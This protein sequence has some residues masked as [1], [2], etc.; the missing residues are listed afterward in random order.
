MEAQVVRVVALQV[1]DTKVAVGHKVAADTKVAAADTKVAVGHKVAAD[2]KVVA[3]D[4]KVAAGHKVAAA[5][6]KAVAGHKVA[7]ADTKVA[8]GHKVAAADT[9]VAAG[10][11]VAVKISEELLA[12][13]LTTPTLHRQ[14]VLAVREMRVKSVVYGSPKRLKNNIR[15]VH[16]AKTNRWNDV[17][18]ALLG[19]VGVTS[20][21]AMNKIHHPIKSAM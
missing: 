3:A 11:K 8:A 18:D 21:R 10:H 12:L 4:T 15:K 19:T 7:A 20:T 16:L 9:K 2:T 6:T 14:M 17:T 5:D 1:A 13:F